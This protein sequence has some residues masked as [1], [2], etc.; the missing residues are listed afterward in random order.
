MLLHGQADF[1]MVQ[2]GQAASCFLVLRSR[3]PL[4]NILFRSVT[5]KLFDV[6]NGAKAAGHSGRYCTMC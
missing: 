5:A 6:Q 3:R 1:V 2:N 4:A